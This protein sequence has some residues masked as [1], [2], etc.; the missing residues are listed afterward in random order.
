MGFDIIIIGAGLAGLSA[1]RSILARGDLS[2]AIIEARGIG[3][4]TPSPL[5]FLEVL[6]EHEL[7][8]C[9]KEKYSTFTFHNINGSSVKYVFPNESLVVLDYRKACYKIFNQLDTDD[10]NLEFID[11]YV[12]NI[13]P[14]SNGIQVCLENGNRISS[15]ILIDASG[16]SQLV[17]NKFAQRDAA[18]YS[19]V[20][21]ALFTNVKNLSEPLCCFLLPSQQLGSGGGWFYS[22]GSNTASFGYAHITNHPKTNNRALK[23]IFQMA[24]EKFK[25]YSEFLQHAKIHRL[26]QGVIPISH[27]NRF[28]YDNILI[29]GDAAGMATNWTCMGIEPALKYGELAGK[30]TAAAIME[31]GYGKLHHFQEEWERENK[32]AFG[33]MMKLA[34]TFWNS[35]HY[36]WEWIIKNDLAYLSPEQAISR[37]KNNDH[38]LKKHQIAART[39]NYKIRSTINPK[40]LDPRSYIINN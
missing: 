7:L 23:T 30:L 9:I 5:T 37:L 12:T 29:V 8:D 14:I 3:A 1:A 33:H 26:E 32:A 36:F 38:L 31:D 2:L 39:L 21:G 27:V 34:P 24:Q 15:R 18:Y 22:I 19:H 40:N 17:A 11:E 25:P 35:D 10:H 20:Y 16:K 28:V 6:E 4:N 13:E